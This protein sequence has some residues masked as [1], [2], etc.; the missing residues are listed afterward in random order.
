MRSHCLTQL[1]RYPWH[2]RTKEYKRKDKSDD[3]PYLCCSLRAPGLHGPP[4]PPS[5]AVTC[6]WPKL[7]GG[8]AA[9]INAGS[10]ERWC[11]QGFGCYECDPHKRGRPCHHP[12]SV[13]TLLR[14]LTK[15]I[16]AFKGLQSILAV[17]APE[18]RG[19]N[20]HYHFEMIPFPLGNG[21]DIPI[22]TLKGLF[23]WF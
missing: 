10:T 3:R 14:T 15:N 11:T 13:D 1:T 5:W 23:C 2:L 19:A 17:M 9:R 7:N 8:L 18:I 21:A 22:Q 12:W 4:C 6:H 20:N 16:L